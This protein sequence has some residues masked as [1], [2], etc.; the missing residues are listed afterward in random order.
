MTTERP[1]G[2]AR[3]RLD[4]CRCYA[5]G[6]A[7]SQYREAVEHARRRGTWQPWTDAAPVRAHIERLRSCGMGVR[8][9]ASVAGVRRQRLQA[10]LSGRPERGT[11]P[12][13]QVRPALAAAVLAVEPTLDNLG[14]KAVISSLGTTRRLQA[15]VAQGWPMMHLAHQLGWAP[16][17]F[18]VLMKQPTVIVATARLVRDAYAQLWNADP[19][20][21]GAT[22]VG[23]TRAK[24]Y[25]RRAEWAPTGAWDEETIDDPAARPEWT[26]VCGT[27][28]GE[29]VHRRDGILPVCSPCRE[30]MAEYRRKHRAKQAS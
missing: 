27:P 6:F 13:K 28:Q 23:I 10:I 30:A 18:S 29:N 15:L 8:V 2:Y 25:A 9:I 22:Q 5:C 14:A 17:N 12:Q 7:A 20:E 21:Y 11:G 3:Y 26:G 4:G 24:Q 1:H 16:G 19:A